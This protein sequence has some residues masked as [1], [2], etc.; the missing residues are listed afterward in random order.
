MK[1][2]LHKQDETSMFFDIGTNGELVISNR[3]WL[4]AGAGAAG[5]ALEGYISRFGMRAAPG[6]VDSEKSADGIFPLPPSITGKLSASA[7]A[8]SLIYW[9]KCGS[10]AGSTSPAL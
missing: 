6:A 2:D 5:P 4:I 10:P 9:P 8:A 3:D 7:E 1:L